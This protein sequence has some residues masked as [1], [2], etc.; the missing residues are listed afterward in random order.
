MRIYILGFMGSGKTSQGKKLASKLNYKFYDTDK[1]I[2][3]IAGMSIP[4]IFEA[5]GESWFRDLEADVLRS[6]I[7][8]TDAVISCGGGTPCYFN[9]MQWI[10]TRGV[11]VYFHLPVERIFGRLKTRK[12][13]RPLI[14]NLTDE[15]LRA[16]IIDKLSEREYYYKKA[17][18]T[19]DLSKVDVKGIFASLRENYNQLR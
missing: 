11:S 14:A 16:F 7:L 6:T 13:K 9:N 18:H 4:E 10:N 12:H 5:K 1:I 3:R 2:E 8:H 15:E 19:Y 17:S